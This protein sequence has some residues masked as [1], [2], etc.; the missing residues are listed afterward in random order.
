MRALLIITFVVGAV[1]M[2]VETVPVQTVPAQTVPVPVRTVPVPE[3]SAHAGRGRPV[4]DASYPTCTALLSR[5]RHGVGLRRARDRVS[6]GATLVTVF[7]RDDTLYRLNARL[8]LDHDGVA[9]E[10]P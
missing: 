4:V 3:V 6:G 5:F 9:C 7:S 8:D 1:L 2:T 10:R